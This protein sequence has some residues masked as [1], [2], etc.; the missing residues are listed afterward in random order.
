MAELHGGIVIRDEVLDSITKPHDQ[1]GRKQ[2]HILGS[3]GI[4]MVGMRAGMP[5][6]VEVPR[7]YW[8]REK[9]EEGYTTAVVRCPCG[10]A[11]PHIEI[12]CVKK[13][14]CE[15]YYYYAVDKVLVFN[16]PKTKASA[17]DD[18]NTELQS[19]S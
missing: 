8:Q 7:T 18:A 12:G 17:T 3:I 10:E 11:N 13:C 14:Q 2:P 19:E 4:L 9:N 1:I 5:A 15:R 6:P 16:S